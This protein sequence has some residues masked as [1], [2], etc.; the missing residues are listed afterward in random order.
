MYGTVM[1]G[2]MA[3]GTTVEDFD[4]VMKEWLAR[5]VDGF[6]DEQMMLCDDG[7]TVVMSVRFR[8]KAAYQALADDPGQDE[9]YSTRIAPVL[10]GDPQWHD[11][12]WARE[13][14]A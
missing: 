9:F 3:A 7:R 5:D 11:G 4:G 6:V 12:E 8:D 10:E 1:I 2:T 14:H 13:Y